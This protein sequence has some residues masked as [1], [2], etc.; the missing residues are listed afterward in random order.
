MSIKCTERTMARCRFNIVIPPI[1][2]I[3]RYGYVISHTRYTQLRYR[4]YK[5][6]GVL[7]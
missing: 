5:S 6:L 2:G 3:P 7:K 1:V 4:Y